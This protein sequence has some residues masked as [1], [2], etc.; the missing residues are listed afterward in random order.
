MSTKIPTIFVILLCGLAL[1]LAGCQGASVGAAPASVN[2]SPAQLAA[3][4]ASPAEVTEAYYQWY[5]DY[6]GDPASED[7]RN[8][9]T[10][11]AYQDNPY[12]TPDF[13]ARV[14]EILEQNAGGGGYDPFLCAQAIPTEIKLDGVFNSGDTASAVVRTDFFDHTFSVDLRQ[15]DG[16]WQISDINCATSPEGSAEAF[17][18]WY[19]ASFGDRD[20]GKFNNPLVE[21]A[22][23]ESGFLTEDFVQ[24]LDAALEAGSLHADPL[25]LAQDVPQSFSVDPGVVPGT[26]IVHAQYGEASV[27]HLLVTLVEELG[28]WKIDQ[29]E[30]PQN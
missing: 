26:A 7:F 3:T 28:R 5:L 19:L 27:N 9:L 15:V 20:A 12:L 10:D 22:Y 25:L 8:P 29:V 13:E 23:R 1:S 2:T 24:R 11:R 17:Y 4:E 16:V 30:L 18:T 14:D 6:I 21:R